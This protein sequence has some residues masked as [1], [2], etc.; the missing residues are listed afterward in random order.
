MGHDFGDFF[1]QSVAENLV[2]AINDGDTLGRIGGDEF[3][4]I[5]SR[6][7]DEKQVFSYVDTIRK[8]LSKPFLVQDREVY[9]TGSF[10][11]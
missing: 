9:T 4:L 3:A 2:S 7:L 1:I 10:V 8:N 6:E 5:I 11:L